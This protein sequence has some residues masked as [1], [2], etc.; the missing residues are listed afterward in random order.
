ML[1]PRKYCE[2]REHFPDTINHTSRRDDIALADECFDLSKVCLGVVSD[3]H[4][5]SDRPKISLSSMSVANS[6]RSA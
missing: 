5:H 6:L 3:A 2:Q 1:Q 4:P